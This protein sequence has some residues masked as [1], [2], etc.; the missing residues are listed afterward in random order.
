MLTNRKRAST[1]RAQRTRSAVFVLLSTLLIVGTGLLLQTA[2][3]R[4]ESPRVIFPCHQIVL[5]LDVNPDQKNVLTI[6]KTLA[7]GVVKKLGQA[8]HCR[9]P[10]V[11]VLWRRHP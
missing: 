10:G 5:L 3:A 2:S 7:E 4:Q 11:E 8:R 1:R 9:R 6:E